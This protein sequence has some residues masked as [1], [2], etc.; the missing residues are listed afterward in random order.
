M[1]AAYVL[2]GELTRA[3]GL[4]E[5]AFTRY[6]GLLRPFIASKQQGAARFASAFAPKTNWGLFVRNSAV[7]AAAIPGVAKLLFGRDLID[8]LRLPGY[9]FAPPN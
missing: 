4:P 1:T 2:A 5:E 7:R 3:G 9:D 8:P 6:E